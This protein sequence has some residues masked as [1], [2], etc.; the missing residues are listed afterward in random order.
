[1]EHEVSNIDSVIAAFTEHQVERL[2][3]VTRR[4]L[5]YWDR[6]G[7]FSPEHGNPDRRMAF[8]RVYS[9]RD[10]VALRTLNVLR[11]QFVVPLQHLRKV[12]DQ[13]KELPG[14]VWN[15]T[16]LYV[17][18]GRV[19]LHVPGSEQPREVVSGQYVFP[20]EL[21]KVV[22]ATDEDTRELRKRDPATI[23]QI[24]RSRSVA[25]NAD[26]LAGTRIPVASVRRFLEDGY[27]VSEIIR[28]YPSLTE[29][30]VEAVRQQHEV[31]NAA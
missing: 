24:A 4:Q 16:T 23:G 31:G 18:N 6:T 7:F 29:V 25:H 5:R 1:M 22:R 26:V 8:A 17:Q 30:D 15:D 13:L 14:R 10:L 27:A 9:F 20:M 21:R 2:S 12:A 28:E 11:N 19:V 3:G